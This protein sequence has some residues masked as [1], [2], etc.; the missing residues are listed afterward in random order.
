MTKTEKSNK[1]IWKQ[2]SLFEQTTFDQPNLIDTISWIEALELEAQA[3][4]EAREQRT[5]EAF[6][7]QG[8]LESSG[9]SY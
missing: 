7:R 6:A 9:P 5:V 8:S 1:P 2:V 4:I 3:E